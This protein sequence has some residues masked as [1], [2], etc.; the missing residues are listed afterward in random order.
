MAIA[1]VPVGESILYVAHLQQLSDQLVVP[2]N[3]ISIISCN[4][5]E[6]VIL[7]SFGLLNPHF[8]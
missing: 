5:T 1:Q 3:N 8:V 4:L 7:F 2:L 6:I